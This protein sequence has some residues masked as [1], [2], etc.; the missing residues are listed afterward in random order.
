[1]EKNNCLLKGIVLKQE[2]S[3]LNLKLEPTPEGRRYPPPP[4]WNR[5]GSSA[6]CPF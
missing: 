6:K 5:S 1:M 3:F 2:L 4:P